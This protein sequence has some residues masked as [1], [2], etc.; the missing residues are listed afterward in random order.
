M[1]NISKVRTHPRAKFKIGSDE[2]K[3]ER[4][5]GDMTTILLKS[6]V[7]IVEMKFD[8]RMPPRNVEILF[9][10][11]KDNIPILLCILH[12]YELSRK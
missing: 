4:D 5:L 1:Q 8:K 12:T 2:Y 11:E 3:I 10:E 9:L 6:G 7:K